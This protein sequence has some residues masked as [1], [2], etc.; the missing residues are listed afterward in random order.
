[1]VAGSRGTSSTSP[2]AARPIARLARFGTLVA[3][4]G[5]PSAIYESL[6][7]EDI[8]AA[9]DLFRPL[10][11]RSTGQDGFVSIEV[12]PALAH[13]TEGTIA[14]AHRFISRINRPNVLVK[15]P[16]TDEGIPAIRQLIDAGI[17]IN[18][19]LLG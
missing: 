8:V 4:A 6:L 7:I 12:S 5:H 10:N 1:M 11:D 15:V 16:A 14:E 9:S 3:R 18:I 19:T 13:Y 2:N 17:K